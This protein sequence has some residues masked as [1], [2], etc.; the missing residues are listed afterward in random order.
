MQTFEHKRVLVTG[1]SRGLGLGVVEALVARHADVTVRARDV[2]P[3]VLVLNAGAMPTMAPLDAHTWESFSSNWNTDVKATFHWVQ[4]A[5]RLPLENGSR[6]LLS[7]SG[8]AL[9]GLPLSGS[10]RER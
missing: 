2:R 5:L 7:S 10:W 6:V 1:G 8:A 9:E 4:A 3:S